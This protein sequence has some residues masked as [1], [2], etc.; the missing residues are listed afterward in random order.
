MQVNYAQTTSGYCIH[1]DSVKK[2][3][4]N[5]KESV[6]LFQG[7]NSKKKFALDIYWNVPSWKRYSFQQNMGYQYMKQQLDALKG[8]QYKEIFSSNCDIDF[9]VVMVLK[10]T[11]D[12]ATI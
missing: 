8:I 5:F 10:I 2:I 1:K 6:A 4:D 9:N 11:K 3:Y 12:P 7:E